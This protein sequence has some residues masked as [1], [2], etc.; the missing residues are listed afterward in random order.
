[1]RT[2]AATQCEL[3][4]RG[5]EIAILH[6]GEFRTLPCPTYPEIRLAMLPGRGV[7]KGIEAFAPDAIHIATEAPLGIAARRDCMRR[8]FKFTTSFHTKFPEYIHARIGLAPALAY[9]WLRRFHDSAQVVMAGTPAVKA[10]LEA[11]GFKRVVL[12]SRGVDTNFFSPGERGFLTLTR[13]IFLYVGRIAVEKNIEAFLS[14]ELPGSKCVVG[15]G[16]MLGR[17]RAR[18]RDVHFAGLQTTLLPQYYRAADVC[19]FPSRTDTF[20]LVLAEA[21]ACGTPVA[22]FPVQGPI[23]VVGSSRAGVLDDNLRDACL[24][25]L[26]LSRGETRRHAERFSWSAATDQFLGHLIAC[27]A[28]RADEGRAKVREERYPPP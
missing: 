12:W 9:A 17:L 14:L 1:M 18:F 27:R 28:A 7:R 22:A 6:P 2:L 16:P 3:R 4:K 21:M 26:M 23:D 11:R 5:H 13:P 10:E 24:R 25:A 15:D 8:G 19:V 20:G